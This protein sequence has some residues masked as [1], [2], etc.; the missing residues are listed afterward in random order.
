MALVKLPETSNWDT[1]INVP[2]SGDNAYGGINGNMFVGLKS[3]VNRVLWLKNAL[4]SLSSATSGTNTGDETAETIKNKLSISTF[5]ASLFRSEDAPTLRGLLGAAPLA[6]PT[7]TGTPTAPNVIAGDNST[8]VANTNF[9]ATAVAALVNSAPVALATI[10]GLADA[11]GDDANF[12]TT[13]TNSLAGKQPISGNLTTL[14]ALNTA[15]ENTS[16]SDTDLIG[17]SDSTSG[18][19]F[20][21]LTFANV[22]ASILSYLQNLAS[23]TLN[24]IYSNSVLSSKPTVTVTSWSYSTT[25]IMLNVTSHSFVVGDF[26]NVNGLTATTYVP[27]GVWQVSA[28]TT[29]TIVFTVQIAPTGTAGVSSATCAGYVGINGVAGGLGVGQKYQPVTRTSGTIYTTG[30]KPVILLVWGYS[31]SSTQSTITIS[32]SGDPAITFSTATGGTTNGYTGFFLIPPN[33]T[34]FLTEYYLLTKNY[35]ILS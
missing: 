34:Y 21:K 4:S 23:I 32:I 9:V 3:L 24:K 33:V 10:K 13:I 11:M 5:F 30:S 1:D 27:N 26:I 15:T 7:F 12:A 18:F 28:V 31:V 17:L 22:K 25:T 6:S 19:S 14:S 20:K 35:Y 29:T 8:K 16:P 2:D